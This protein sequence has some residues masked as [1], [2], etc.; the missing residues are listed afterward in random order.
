MST[1]LKLG[2]RYI[3]HLYFYI[4]VFYWATALV[5]L[6]KKPSTLS[7]FLIGSSIGFTLFW[8]IEFAARWCVR[9]W[10]TKYA[11]YLP[12][13]IVLGRYTVL[14]VLLYFL[15]YFLVPLIEFEIN[16]I[17]NTF[18]ILFAF[19]LGNISFKIRK[20][21]S[22]KTDNVKEFGG[23]SSIALYGLSFVLA[24]VIGYFCGRWIGGELGNAAIGS[25]IGFALGTAAGV[26]NPWNTAGLLNLLWNTRKIHQQDAA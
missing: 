10:E 6:T 8:S 22:E 7:I 11:K 3:H 14:C 13:I 19:I 25:Y 21:R 24:I 20:R 4:G 9:S 5:M 18:S 16:N 1:V 17:V 12:D 26:L 23:M 2:N 15:L